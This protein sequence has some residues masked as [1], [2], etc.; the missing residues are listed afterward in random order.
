W[1]A[2]QDSC[3][4][5]GATGGKRQTYGPPSEPVTCVAG[6][7]LINKSD[8]S[9]P[10]TVSLNLTSTCVRLFTVTPASGLSEATVGGVVSTRLYCQ[11]A[12]R[13]VGLN[14]LGGEPKSVMNAPGSQEICTGP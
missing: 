10:V 5:P 6:L 4:V 2:T 14:R 3:T 8:A 13:P 11:V 12:P 7:P 9:T 1:P